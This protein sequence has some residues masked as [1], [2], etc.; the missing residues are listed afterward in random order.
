M[1]MTPRGEL[2]KDDDRDLASCAV[3]IPQATSNRRH[4]YKIDNEVL[5]TIYTPIAIH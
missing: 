2:N 3:L 4:E 5:Q 1:A